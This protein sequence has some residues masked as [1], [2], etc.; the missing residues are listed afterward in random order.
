[1]FFMKGKATSR[2]ASYISE[3]A[4]CMKADQRAFWSLRV[5]KIG[6]SISRFRR[7]AFF[8]SAVWISSSRLRKSRNVNCSI[9]SRGLEMPPDHMAVQTASTFDL[10]S[11]VI[12]VV[13][14]DQR[15]GGVGRGGAERREEIRARQ[16]REQ[17]AG[18]MIQS[19]PRR[20]NPRC[21][22]AGL[23]VGPAGCE[24]VRHES[25]PASRDRRPDP[26]DPLARSFSSPIQRLARQ[27]HPFVP[28]RPGRRR[29][30]L[31]GIEVVQALGLGDSRREPTRGSLG[32]R[33]RSRGRCARAGPVRA[34]AGARPSRRSAC[35][36]CG[37]GRRDLPRTRPAA[38]APSWRPWTS[39][40][41]WGPPFALGDYRMHRS[42]A[43][44]VGGRIAGDRDYGGNAA[45]CCSCR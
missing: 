44:A 37:G 3:G 1:M 45:G 10:S 21:P 40:L 31:V 34:R 12:M 14:R 11:P 8:S 35:A 28:R 4:R 29:D 39:M 5:V 18:G 26:I 25:N 38:P 33:G 15:G 13:C 32:C 16:A 30:V 20:R 27:P 19:P 9:T 42:E 36:S 23:R 24:L 41:A 22:R 6:F 7:A 2:T 43:L 17:G